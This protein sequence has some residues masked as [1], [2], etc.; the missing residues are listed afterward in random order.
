MAVW[1]IIIV[2]LWGFLP[3]PLLVIGVVTN[4]HILSAIVFFVLLILFRRFVRAEFKLIKKVGPRHALWC[5]TNNRWHAWGSSPVQWSIAAFDLDDSR[6]LGQFQSK[7]LM[8]I[9]PDGTYSNYF[10]LTSMA[11]SRFIVVLHDQLLPGPKVWL[12]IVLWSLNFLLAMYLKPLKKSFSIFRYYVLVVVAIF[13]LN[14]GAVL[15]GIGVGWSILAAF[16]SLFSTEFV[17][18]FSWQLTALAVDVANL[19]VE[20]NF[21]SRKYMDRRGFRPTGGSG[22]FVSVMRNTISKLAIVVNDL[23]LP[24]YMLGSNISYDAEHVQ[25]TLDIMRDAGWPINVELDDPSRFASSSKYAEWLVS[26]TTWK[27]GIHNRKMYVDHT[28]DPLRVKAVEWRRTEEYRS[29]E[30]EQES[31]A[32]YFKSPRYNYPDLDVE[33]V[34][35]LLGDIFRNSRITPMNYIIKMW[36][37]KYALGSFMVDPRNP[38]KKYSRWKFISTIGYKNFKNLWRKTFEL[39]PLLAPVAHVSVKDEALPAKKFLADKV[40]TVVGSPL[41][42]YIMST[43]WNYSPNHNFR[44]VTTPIKV[45]MPLNGYWMNEVYTNHSRCQLHFAGDMSEFDSTLSGN[46]LKLIASVRKKGFEHHKDRN[47]IAALID[48]NYEQVSRQ[49]LNTTSTGDIYSKG[50]GLTTGHSSTSMDNSVGLVTLYLLAWKELTGLSAQE[51]KFYNELSC[52]GDDHLL[53]MAGNKPAAWN[54]R[55]IQAVMKRWGVTN[56]LEASG[57]L[58]KLQFLS[59]W[60]RLPTPADIED[61]KRAGVPVPKY[62]IVHDRERLIGK[63]VSKVKTLDPIYRL[64]RL[65]SYMSLTPHHPDVYDTLHRLVVRSATFKPYLKSSSNPKGMFVPTYEKVVADWY[66]PDAKFPE[67]MIDEVEETYK[68]DSSIIAYGALTPLDSF[69][70]ALALVPDF[71][72]PAI[73]NF[74][75]MATAQSKLHRMVSW[76]VQLISLANGTSGVAETNFILRKTVYEFLDPSLCSFVDKEANASS[77]LVRHWVFLS[78]KGIFSFRVSDFPLM[79]S[80]RK[81]AQVQFAINGLMQYESKRVS[82]QILELGLIALLGF[83]YVPDILSWVGL[84]RLPDMN[85]LMDQLFY[86]VQSNFWSALPPNYSDVNLHVKQIDNKKVVVISAPTGSGKSTAL[87]KH[88]SLLVGHKYNKIIVVEPRSS[89]VQTIVPYVN[90]TMSMGASGCTTGMTLDTDCDV[91]YVTA[92]EALLHPSWLSC[93][94]GNNLI[95]VDECHV[96]EPAYDLLKEVVLRNQCHSVWVSATPEFSQIPPDRVIDIPLVSARLYS[97]HTTEVHNDL[98]VSLSD[99]NRCY[100]SEVLSTIYERPTSSVMLVFCTTLAMAQD[101]AGDCPRAN[102]VLSSGTRQV[103]LLPSGC[104]IFT[105][106]VAD[107]GI[108]LPDVDF[109]MTPD[110]GF[111][112]LQTLDEAKLSYYRL[113]ASDITQRAGRTGRTN[114]GSCL[115]FRTPRARFIMDITDIKAKTSVFDL[116]ASG[117]PLEYILQMRKPQLMQLLGLDDVDPARAEATLD[118]S[119][120]QLHLYRSNLEPLLKERARLLDIG[121]NDGSAPG[122][123]DTSRMGLIRSHSTISSTDMIRSIVNVAKHLGLR[124]TA[125]EDQR[126]SHEEEIR[127]YSQFLIGNM[128]AKIPFPDPDLGEWGMDPNPPDDDW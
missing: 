2:S 11:W 95:V 43:V 18:W 80:I 119:L 53:S 7:I 105:T 23:G 40:R 89:I 94:R 6:L 104:V 30:N 60:A 61:C 109:V 114:N 42:Q 14:P 126:L 33:D 75:Y 15:F 71:I 36:E 52:F 92:Q 55:S 103:P 16:L 124:F 106:S 1:P 65:I 46:V 98:V 112:V 81:V 9:V 31:I 48:I 122:V 68:A 64:K 128:K 102:F 63:M 88:L 70:G 4:A 82:M 67:N 85:K 84:V 34:W 96:S 19:M 116:L 28:L 73:F 86:V 93:E 83:V 17:E 50:T 110:I 51:F 79:H 97:V 74:G 111:T 12:L 59:K 58:T 5:D 37:K 69:L 8:K 54:F 26:G 10:E 32:R 22:G 99:F 62:A 29:Y 107:V 57:P 20:W 115:V 76:P 47:R 123:I 90:V 125:N 21:V 87:I 121:T 41:G 127:N 13:S 35:F 77:L 38:K 91:W 3:A 66:K 24:S 44:W 49:L 118:H 108:T 25:S 78:L 117:I 39:A 45:G 100:K 120:Q 101:L 72:N 27:Q 56:N 113:S